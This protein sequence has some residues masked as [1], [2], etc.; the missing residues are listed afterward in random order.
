MDGDGDKNNAGVN[1]AAADL[2]L[3]AKA[4]L[5]EVGTGAYLKVNGAFVEAKAIYRK[6]NGSWVEV[7]KTVFEAGKKYHVTT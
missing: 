1:G 3:Y 6:S 7:D 2:T 4:A 5:S